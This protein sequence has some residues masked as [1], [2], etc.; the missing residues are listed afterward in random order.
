M[1]ARKGVLL[2]L[3]PPRLDALRSLGHLR[4]PPHPPEAGG[5]PRPSRD[6][7]RSDALRFAPRYASS[8]SLG[9]APPSGWLRPCSTNE[10]NL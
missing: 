10:E 4:W 6:S 5:K 8:D 7:A 1:S 3:R 9:G 2:S